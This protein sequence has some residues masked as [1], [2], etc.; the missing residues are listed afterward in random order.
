MGMFD[1][2]LIT[3]PYCDEYTIIQS[4][5]ADCLLITY[6]ITELPNSIKHDI[7]GTHYCDSCNG[8]YHIKLIDDE[9]NIIK[10]DNEICES[11]KFEDTCIGMSDPC[12]TCLSTVYPITGESKEKYSEWISK[13]VSWETIKENDIKKFKEAEEFFNKCMEDDVFKKAF[14]KLV[15]HVKNRVLK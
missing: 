10:D 9:I 12:F 1:E 4:K 13:K 2:V 8:K 5:A 3:C 7:I 11:C 14:N 6:R 15:D